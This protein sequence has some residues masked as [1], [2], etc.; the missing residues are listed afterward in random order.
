MSRASQLFLPTL[1][2]EPADSDAASHRLLVRAGFIRQVGAGLWSFLPLGWRVHQKAVQ[3]VREEMDAIGGQEMLMPVLTPAELW[4]ETGRYGIP[5]LYKLADRAGRPFVLP[6]THEETVTFH[7]REIRSYRELPQI[8]YHFQT[9]DRDEPR[10][11]GGLLRVREFIMKD[12]YSFDRDEEGLDESFQMHAEAYRR[13]FER[14]GLESYEVEAEV[15]MM[16]GSESKDYLAPAGSGENVLVTCE[17]GDYAA[18]LEIAR[19]VP[20][21]PSFPASLTQPDEVETPG[22]TTIEGL[23]EL[24]GIDAAAT[25]KAMP[26]VTDGRVVLGLVRGDDRLH[27]G[28]LA[29]ALGA[30]F[31]P[32]TEEEIRE[33]F[34]ADP[35]SIGP[36]GIA[37]EVVADEALREGQFVAGANRTGRHLL[38]VEVGRDYEARFADIREARE[39][40]A[41][42]QCGGALRFQVAIEVGHI[43]KLGTRY[44]RPLRAT[45]LDEG[46][47]ER[48]LVMGSYGIGPGRIMAAAVEQNHDA[49]GIAWPRPLA[50]YEIEIVPIEA[51]GAEALA[52]AGRLEDDLEAAGLHVLLDDRGRRPGE[53]FA[54]ADLIGCPFRI[55]VG[56]RALEDGKVDLR[57]RAGKTEERLPV[58]DVLPR[59][60]TAA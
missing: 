38:G 28:K 11:R 53:K 8:L 31:R 54:D 19:G 26:V 12:S 34:G 47:V 16:G 27:E 40:D 37:V 48:P 21:P 45:Y 52:I 2:E 24:L 23:A 30:E 20:R 32:A 18:D 42:P 43:F 59:V 4:Q 10:P 22:V 44:S 9:K 15:G 14:C 13:I 5:E 60:R 50:P 25:S 3:I 33:T 46:G 36:V 17:R 55:T 35:G 41:C 39:G 58:G 56:K 7:A 29:G 51:A 6:M 1:R 49:E 57:E